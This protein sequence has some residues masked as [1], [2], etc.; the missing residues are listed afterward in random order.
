[1]GYFLAGF[2][3]IGVDTEQHPAYPFATLDAD[4]WSVLHDSELLFEFDAVH[5][6]RPA[7]LIGL[8]HLPWIVEDDYPIGTVGGVE[9]CRTHFRLASA[10]HRFYATSFTLPSVPSCY[11]PCSNSRLIPPDYTRW[12]GEHLMQELD[13]WAFARDRIEG[14]VCQ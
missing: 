12:I 4:P 1:M 13:L 7:S 8:A 10:A 6:G 5:V 9:L 14:L 3:V 11:C 2:D